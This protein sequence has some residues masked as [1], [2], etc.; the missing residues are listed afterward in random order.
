M[1][2]SL[3]V[4][5]LLLA[6]SLAARAQF[7]TPGE[8][9]GHLRWY[10]VESPYYKV[11]YPEG[12]DSLARR[13]AQLLEQFREPVGRS[14]GHTPKSGKWNRKM[15][16]V[17]HTHNM[18]ANGSVA[19]APTRMDLYTLPSAYGSDP[20]SWPIQLAA[21]EPRHQAQLEKLEDAGFF[22]GLS[23]AIGQGSAPLAWAIYLTG[24]RGEGDAV[25]AET[26]LAYGTR[27]RT[28][29]FLNFMQVAFDQGDWRS[30]TL[31]SKGSYKHFTPDYYKAGYVMM[32]GARYLYGIPDYTSRSLDVKVRKP[33]LFA[34][35]NFD[36]VL[37]EVIGKKEEE[38]FR[39]IA[40]AFKEVWN[41]DAA[42]RAPFLEMTQITPDRD[43]PLDYSTPV[44]VEGDLYAVREGYL[45]NTQLVR[46]SGGK[47]KVLHAY[48]YESSSLY[49]D[50]DWNRIYWSET[51]PHPRW[52]LSGSSVVCY[53]DLKTQKI[54]TLT[55]G[56]RMYN[57]F[58]SPSGDELATV[59][60]SVT[61]ET[62]LT[63]ISARDGSFLQ[64]RKAPEGVQITEAAWR[65]DDI[66]CLGITDEGYGVFLA[67]AGGGW[68]TVLAPNHQKMVNLDAVENYL[69]WVSDRTGVNE[70]YRYFPEE[71]R[72]LQLTSTRYGVT[73][74]TY[75]DENYYCISQ[76]LNGG[77]IF[78]IS[79]S[80]ITPREVSFEDLHHY[81]IEEAI[82]A[83]ERALGP[84]PDL[85]QEVALSEPK[86]Y[87]KLAHPL[88]L[89]TWLPL[90]VDVDD[91]MAGSFEFSYETLSPGA[92][93]M[94]QNTLG[95]LSGQ[96]GIAFH[97]NPDKADGWR[98][99]LH[100]KLT[101]T[102]QYPV[103]EAQIDYGDRL[104]RQYTLTETREGDRVSYGN[105][106]SLR[107]TP[108]LTGSL[109][110]YIPFSFNRYGL[111]SG[112]IPQLRYSFSNNIYS[113][114]S[115][116][117]TRGPLSESP[118]VFNGA[119][120]AN[121]VFMQ[122]LSASARGYVMLPKAASQIY[123]RWGLGLEG[124]AAFRPG[125]SGAFKPVVYA[126][127][128]AYTPGILRTQGIM[129]TA[130]VQHQLGNAPFGDYRANVLPRGFDSEVSSFLSAQYRTQWKATL[131]YAIP[132]YFGDLE[133]PVL[134]YI[135]KFLLTPHGDFTG[136]G[137]DFLWS[138]GADFT[139]DFGQ[140][141][142][143]AI[144]T[145]LGVSFSYLG[146]NIYNE[147]EQKKPY[148]VSL[149]LSFNL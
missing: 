65:G 110:A 42:A 108:L 70:L 135:R 10:S 33:W 62:Y 125:M 56:T 63:V 126:H 112:F 71:G 91:V 23:Y 83:Q 140:I 119:D 117:F 138:A 44:C 45:H 73:D 139:A 68:S 58:P 118:R 64:R 121:N 123:P 15:P 40:H 93:G 134:G 19:W 96:A 72:L 148:S 28:A 132:L 77:K 75:D 84:A 43:F 95:T 105:A 113:L 81:T 14:V 5:T 127:A 4:L 22:K 137:K 9:P 57:P 103:L 82:T 76:T 66:Y 100:G 122:Q 141:F 130:T 30:T 92:I 128:Y 51:R 18:Y 97:P 25:A 31:W 74:F 8:D 32:A 136:L 49:Y 69:E 80:E 145:T 47:E 50:P 111:L 109:R 86:R 46:F 61:G 12:A 149:I 79:L 85:K 99:A 67:P 7:Y 94:F 34:P 107:S 53:L 102:G 26:G 3:T 129:L 21:H 24:P 48:T 146:G 104:A 55:H 27:A 78:R 29:D 115:V 90:Y 114:G 101:Y 98:T 120:K 20:V 59:E 60:Y 142:F 11:I 116:K 124:G 89:H 38:S 1:R 144:D 13:Y 52:T 143:L 87:Y 35:Y 36:T 16:V 39:E 88:R 6:A 147:T 106:V 133:I 131:D 37:K 2:K 41:A 54:H 17:L